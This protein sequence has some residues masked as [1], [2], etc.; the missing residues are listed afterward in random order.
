MGDATTTISLDDFILEMMNIPPTELRLEQLRALFDRLDLCRELVKQ[1]IFFAEESYARNLLCRT[2]R[3]DMLV[4]CWRPGQVTT[5]H[6]HAGSLNCTRVCRGTLTSRIYEVAGVPEPGRVTLKLAR[7][8]QLTSDGSTSD[9]D[10]DEIHQLANTSNEDLVTLHVYARPLKDI[11]VYCLESGKVE[12][13]ALRYT[14]E[15]E[16]A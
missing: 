8:E 6:D 4:L 5:V 14:L 13:V 11:N 15:D 12:R 7:E 1:H 16:F 9:V 2:P 10:Y 3:F